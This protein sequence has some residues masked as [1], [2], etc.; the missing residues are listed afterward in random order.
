MRQ[1]LRGRTSGLLQLARHEGRHVRSQISASSTL[2]SL[3]IAPNSFFEG[4]YCVK[5][6]GDR[7]DYSNRSGSARRNIKA[8]STSSPRGDIST[9]L[10]LAKRTR[11]DCDFDFN[12]DLPGFKAQLFKSA[13]ASIH[14]R[15]CRSKSAPNVL[16]HWSVTTRPP[17]ESK[18][19]S[20]GRLLC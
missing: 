13:R 19:R 14:R 4:S 11:S 5:P 7:N 16:Y 9:A 6:S 8:A 12:R 10:P 20:P 2:A 18:C 15:I 3:W 1:G 17:T